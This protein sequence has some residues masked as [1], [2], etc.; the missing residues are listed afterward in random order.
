MFVTPD[1]IFVSGIVLGIFS[2]PSV[3]SA[4]SDRRPP[5]IASLVLVTAG[6]LVLWAMHK[7]PGGYS[8]TEIPNAF[9]RVVGAI[10]R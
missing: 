4:I 6:C 8:L 2:I 10:V 3:I 7:N 1:L 9:V 5:R